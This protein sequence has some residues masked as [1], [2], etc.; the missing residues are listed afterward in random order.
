LNYT[1]ILLDK[2]KVKYVTY[3]DKGDI[4]KSFIEDIN[5]LR[6]DTTKVNV[7]ENIDI[8]NTEDIL[9]TRL[10]G[11]YPNQKSPTQKNILTIYIPKSC[12]HLHNDLV[13]N[14]ICM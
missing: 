7:K 11:S 3:N 1:Q 5:I 12:I 14:T 9:I 8:F 13:E 6:E 2:E 4:G 10:Y